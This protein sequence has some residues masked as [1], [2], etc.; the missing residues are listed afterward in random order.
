MWKSI[1]S[2]FRKEPVLVLSCLCALV[3]CLF[4]PPS[5]DYLSYIDVRVLCLLFCLMAVVAGLQ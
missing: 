1:S 5:L 4:V 2:F 3:S